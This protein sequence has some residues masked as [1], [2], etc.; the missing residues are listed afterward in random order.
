MGR[1][2]KSHSFNLN[3]F[4]QPGTLVWCFKCTNQEV[5]PGKRCQKCGAR[6]LVAS[7]KKYKNRLIEIRLTEAAQEDGYVL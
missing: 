3:G 2:K 7:P 5:Q 6:C 1:V 4:N